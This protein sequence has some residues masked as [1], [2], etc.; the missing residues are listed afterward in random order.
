MTDEYVGAAVAA[1]I[2][3]PDGMST[4]PSW[5]FDGQLELLQ[6]NRI[7][8]AVLSVSSPGVSFAGAEAL[9]L[10]QHVND[11]AASTVANTLTP[12]LLLRLAA[13][14]RRRCRGERSN[15]RYETWGRGSHRH[16]QQLRA[17]PGQRQ[18][19]PHVA[20]SL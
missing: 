10:A 14:A 19:L 7:R 4:W 20:A 9:A 11:F 18:F 17:V 13:A 6:D 15:P 1:G 3:Q 16:E 8:H 5:T 2:V 12:F